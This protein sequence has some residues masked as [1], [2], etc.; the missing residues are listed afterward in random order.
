[1]KRRIKCPNCL[2]EFE[3]PTDLMNRNLRCRC[4]V[5]FHVTV[6]LARP[7]LVRTEE[8]IRYLRTDEYLAV[9]DSLEKT[10]DEFFSMDNGRSW[11][12]SDAVFEML[13]VSCSIVPETPKTSEPE[14]PPPEEHK[15]P[16]K[17]EPLE[18]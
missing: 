5:K 16:A 10:T 17:T 8:G 6:S 9:C 12:A 11:I 13:K 4:G 7:T 1:M 2:T 15:S 3:V 14:P 18:Y